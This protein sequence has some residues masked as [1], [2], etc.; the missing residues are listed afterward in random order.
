M[1]MLPVTPPM[2]SSSVLP[3]SILDSHDYSLTYLHTYKKCRMRID[4]DDDVCFLIF[5]QDLNQSKVSTM[6]ELLHIFQ[7]DFWSFDPLPS[8]SIF[9]ITTNF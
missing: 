1:Y 6:S 9:V 4:G 2:L 7:Q 8:L 3:L 5:H